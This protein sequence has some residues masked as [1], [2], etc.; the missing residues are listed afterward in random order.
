MLKSPK[1]HWGLLLAPFVL[2]ACGLLK[3]NVNGKVHTL[4]E[5]DPEEQEEQKQASSSSSGKSSSSGSSSSGSSGSSKPKNPDKAAKEEHDKLRKETRTLLVEMD[6]MLLEGPDPIPG[7]KIG[8]MSEKQSAFEDAGLENE[9]RYLAHVLT[10]YKLENAWRADPAKTGETL[11]KQLKGA[12]TTQGELSGKDKPVSFKFQAEAGKCYTVMSH[13]KMAGGD[14]DGASEFFLDGGAKGSKLQRFNVPTRTSR[15]SGLRR[16]LAKAYTYGACALESTEVTVSLKMKYAGTANGLRYVVVEHARD[17]FPKYLAIDLQPT[18]NDSCDV[19][20][21]T[22][23]WTNPLPAAVVYGK[24]Q[25]FLTYDAGTADEMWMT[26]WSVAFGEARLKRG[27]VVSTPPKQFKFDDKPR[28]RKCPHEMKYA[29]SAEG[30]KVAQCYTALN[31]RYDPLFDAAER[32]KATAGSLLGEIN[33]QKRLDALNHQYDE[34]ENRTCRKIEADVNKKLEEAYNKIVDFY[35]TSPPK[36]SFDRA[37]EM[38]QQHEG[39]AEIR[40]VGT[41]TCSL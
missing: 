2:G 13:M 29:H 11:A 25:P 7:D 21:Y 6:K 8:A 5:P 37:G 32:A 3:V 15:G 34:E 36:P 1:S 12:V 28:F 18:M 20:N 24:T 41:H 31:K 14:D 39:L 33:A 19:E 10:Y 40:C 27:D 4:G 17:K 26:A 38:H 30:I 23:M 22:N 16:R 9:A 35:M